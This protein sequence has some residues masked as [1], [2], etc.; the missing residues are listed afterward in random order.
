M[1]IFKR[2]AFIACGTAVT[3]GSAMAQGW[4]QECWDHSMTPQYSNDYGIQGVFNDII[5]VTMGI[6]GT[7]RWGGTTGPCYAPTAR[8]L[9]AVGRLSFF[10]GPTGS[11]QSDVDDN[12]A[13]TTGA[14]NDPVGDFCYGKITKDGGTNANSVLFGNGGL[15]AFYVGASKRYAISAWAD[16]DVD[17]EL[18]CKVIADAVR[19]RWHMRNLK[20]DPQTLG[21]LF[22]CYAGMITQ[23]ADST[24]SQEMNSPLPVWDGF[25]RKGFDVNTNGY[26]GYTML[27]NGKP[28]RNER[29]YAID[30]PKFPAYMLFE[31]GQS[32]PY[33]MRV[34]NLPGSETPDASSTDLCLIG[35]YGDTQSPGLIH[36]NNI[37]L[38]VFGDDP[39]NPNP[40]EEADIFLNETAFVQ[41]FPGVIVP[42]LNS[43][44]IVH[45]IRSPWGVADYADPYA[46][47]IDAP[48]LVATDP[49]GQNGLSPNP[50]TIRAY[51]DNQYATLDK[52]VDLH[53][54]RFTIF[55]PEG[56]SLAPGETQ[57]KTLPL[58]QANQVSS[59]EWRVV[60][61]GKIIGNLP[62]SVSIAPSP[63]P[64]K[65]L[66]GTV[67]VSATPRLNLPSGANL[68]TIP[69]TFEDSSF[70][71]ILGL[72]AGADYVAYR[73]D[74]D[75]SSYIPAIS[76][77]RG[78]GY[79]VLPTSDQ[80]YRTLQ[81]A[82]M[83]TDQ[84]LGG[85][86]V[87]LHQGWNLIGNPYSFGVPLNQL[88]LVAED[89]PADSFTWIEAVQA[90]YVQSSLIYFL[91]DDTQPGGGTY[92][93]T[94][95]S[96]DIL[97]PH[98]GYWIYVSTFK[99]VRISWPPVF[100]EGLPNSGRSTSVANWAQNDRQWR[101]QLS[102]RSNNGYDSQNYVGVVS[103]K[104]KLAELR[105]LKAPAAPKQ[106]LELFIEDQVDGKAVRMTQAL[107]DRTVR[108]E[109]N[110][111][112]KST[113]AGDVT[114]TWP[115]LPSVPRNLRLKVTDLASGE[116][117]DLRSVSGYT[118][119][120][121][122][123][124]VRKLKVTIEPGG[125]SRP[126]IGNVLVTRSSR[127]SNSPVSVSY[128]L[129]AD[130]LVTVRVLSSTGKEVF[131]L[132]RGRAD[133]AGQNSVT[134]AM[135]D[136]ANRTVAPGVYRMEIL[137]ETPNGE[138]VRR[139]VPIN[140]LR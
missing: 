100:L 34:D 52:E 46:A 86:L 66:S 49:N 81:N 95:G 116:S 10:A 133:N 90:G 114:V 4:F 88:V 84:A 115:N 121:Q 106:A 132:T 20:A 25:L 31:S 59:V 91:R 78:I 62:Y 32:E 82:Q 137:A 125:S 119:R 69:Y 74:P 42:S 102:A 23:S 50:F 36:D 63:G 98:R 96:G 140:V 83:P 99:P 120:M 55:L 76:V 80:G 87:S 38:Q 103:D 134:W 45:Y 9:N 107:S 44:D 41:R 104:K 37:R 72:Q 67:R 131:T 54:V 128:A 92:V 24:G 6:S 61:D 47:V 2:I 77:D 39:N 93:Y 43:I 60:S 22:A 79:W 109:W 17:V 33:G 48:R 113:V 3:A 57:Q 89:N 111:N 136:N 129:S 101:L 13:F 126:V 70:D 97:E 28:V 117:H 122:Q 85:L 5:G 68:V 26:I 19:L 21:L 51:I 112:V 130:A 8:T 73:W 139:L 105:L 1:D 71:S 40:K 118:F 11:L 127:D 65:T 108:K 35:N 14:P 58:V 15:R 29:R 64:V 138:R 18:Q 135:R 110:V 53:T 94:Q 7:S 124:G 12:M 123:P 30:N 75:Q 16:G 56:L 27:S